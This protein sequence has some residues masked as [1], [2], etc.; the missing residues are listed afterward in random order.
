MQVS[1]IAYYEEEA[2]LKDLILS[3]CFGPRGYIVRFKEVPAI[4]SSKVAMPH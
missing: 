1:C 4:S 3:A 2:M